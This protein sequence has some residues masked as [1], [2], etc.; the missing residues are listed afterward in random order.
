MCLK[1]GLLN[2]VKVLEETPRWLLDL[3]EAYYRVEPFGDE[4]RQ[5]GEIAAAA[6]NAG[7]AGVPF[8]GDTPF[9][10]AE[11]FIPGGNPDSLPVG[12]RRLSAD[13]ERA[14]E[15]KAFGLRS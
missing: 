1:L 11:H 13:E 6:H 15:E 5:A 2:P 3:W 7:I 14:A 4:W 9:L 12:K 10:T 8:E